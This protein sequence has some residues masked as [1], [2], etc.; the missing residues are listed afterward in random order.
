MMILDGRR[1]IAMLAWSGNFVQDG[2]T[3]NMLDSSGMLEVIE[4]LKDAACT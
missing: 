2:K 4:H 1:L 3:S